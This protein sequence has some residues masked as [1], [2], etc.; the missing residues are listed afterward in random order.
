MTLAE[1]KAKL[2]KAKEARAWVKKR[3]FKR[4]ARVAFCHRRKKYWIGKAQAAEREKRFANA[5]R[6]EG[7]VAYWRELEDKAILGRK[8]FNLRRKRLA[9]KINVLTEKVDEAQRS[10]A[11]PSSGV[12]TPDRAWNGYGRTIAN[13]IIPWLDR[14]YA[15]G[16]RFTVVSGY[17]SDA[18]QCQTCIGVCGNCG[19]CS[20]TCAPPGTS[21]HR[22]TAY[23]VGAV[24]VTNYY[25]VEAALA[26][27]GSPLHNS[28]GSRDPVHMSASGY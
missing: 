24:D 6:A 14:I 1:D 27:V 5:E 18:T 21:N 15:N 8:E 3:L 17:R 23:P 16:C 12:S 2:A 19:G 10:Q 20:G 11:L 13:W 25:A 22:G 4:R 7:K 9:H 26:R 28:L